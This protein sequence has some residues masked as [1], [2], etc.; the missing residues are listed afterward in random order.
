LAFSVFNIEAPRCKQRGMRSLF[1]S[2]DTLPDYI[3]QLVFDLFLQDRIYNPETGFL[4]L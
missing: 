3:V 2:K 4:L 1:S